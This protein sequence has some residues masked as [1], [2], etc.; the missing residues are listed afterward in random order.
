MIENI[1]TIITDEDAAFMPAIK[2]IQN[3]KIDIKIINHV[4]CALHKTKNWKKKLNKSSLPKPVKQLLNVH[5]ARVCYCDN[6]NIVNQSLD[7]IRSSCDEIRHY[8]VNH[9]EPMLNHFSRSHI[10]HI[11]TLGYN[12]TSIAESMNNMI[13]HGMNNRLMS[14]VQARQTIN[15][16][17]EFHYYNYLHINSVKQIECFDF[18]TQNGITLSNAI[19]ELIKSEIEKSR[20]F[21]V[22]PC[23]QIMILFETNRPVYVYYIDN[24]F[25]CNCGLVNYLGIPCSHIIALCNY[26]CLPFPI[27]LIKEG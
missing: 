14:L 18:E 26:Y 9:I 6:I 19:R 25:N 17:L 4:V 24:E 20:N 22:E 27:E 12:T 21:S 15:E 13:K 16:S 23:D 7:I 2:K 3:E 8:F 1:K 5:F 11:F 10:S